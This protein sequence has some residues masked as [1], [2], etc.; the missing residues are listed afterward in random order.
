MIRK[1]I[2][3]KIGGY[4]N[5][6]YQGYNNLDTG[7]LG[8]VNQ[9][10]NGSIYENSDGRYS[11][12]S[13]DQGNYYQMGDDLTVSEGIDLGVTASVED[14]SISSGVGGNIEAG[15]KWGFEAGNTVQRTEDEIIA[16]HGFKAGAEIGATIGGQIFVTA[17]NQDGYVAGGISIN[18]GI[19]SVGGFLGALSEAR[20]NTNDWNISFFS[21]LQAGFGAAMGFDLAINLNGQ[22]TVQD[23]ISQISQEINQQIEN[24]QWLIMN[25][26]LKKFAASRNKN[27]WGVDGSEEFQFQD[28]QTIRARAREIVLRNITDW[29]SKLYI[30]KA[31]FDAKARNILTDFADKVL[32]NVSAATSTALKSVYNPVANLV[33]QIISA[34]SPS[35]DSAI[36]QIRVEDVI[37][38]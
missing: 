8:D 5:S 16:R 33:A 36:F 29:S 30:V 14:A 37:K 25:D 22:I 15:V 13:D 32:M 10:E 24:E 38:N 3:H 23:E 6:Y 35:V 26:Q 1:I 17:E 18:K 11:R 12:V 9:E 31:G 19:L 7:D 21:S 4:I 34:V 20:I 27:V 2:N 28:M